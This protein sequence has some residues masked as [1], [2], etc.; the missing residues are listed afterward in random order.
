[1]SHVKMTR[2]DFLA[3]GTPTV[4]A[5]VAGR[6]RAVRSAN[7]FPYL[8]LWL[9]VE[10]RLSDLIGRMTIEAKDAQTKC[11]GSLER[12]LRDDQGNFSHA[13]IDSD[14]P[15]GLPQ[16]ENLAAQMGLTQRFPNGGVNSKE[17]IVETTGSGVAIFDYDN[18]GFPDIFIVS[19]PGGSNRLY[20]NDGR[21]HFVD[22]TRQMGLS[23]SGW[24]QGVC[25][26]DYDNDG[27]VDL[28]VTYFGHNILYHNNGGRFFEDVTA[29]A[30]LEEAE[31]R[32]GTG[33][34]FLD[35]DRDGRLDLFVANYLRFDF[36]NAPRPGANPYCWYRGL[37]VAC[38]PRGLPFPT[39]LLYRNLGNG[40]FVDVSKASGISGPHQNYSLGAL[41]SDFNGDG[42][43][44]IYV[45]CDR[46][47]SLLYINQ[48]NGTF[49]EEGLLRGVAL[50]ETGEALSGM[51]VA[52]ADYD[53]NGWLD[54]FRTNFSD[55]HVSLYR[56][57]G[58]GNFDD[59]TITAGLGASTGFVGWG[60][61]FVDF[62]NDTWRDLLWVTGHTF[63]EVDK[64]KTDIHYKDRIIL[65]RNRGNGTFAD[66][67][68]GAGPAFAERHSSRGAAFGDLDNDGAIE[69]VVNNQNECPSLLKDARKRRGN[70][71]L[72]KLEGTLSN[73][74]AIG[75][76]ALV[77]TGDSLQ[78][79]EVRSG[80]SYVSQNDLRLHFGLGKATAVDRVE[81]HWPSGI[82]QIEIGL[83]VNRVL[84]IR[85]TSQ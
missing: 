54:I 22:V 55:E 53:K 40:R 72:L 7:Q 50:D 80:G 84:T 6:A 65:Y 70:W 31:T 4:L 39:N 57:T 59:A 20:H 47:P 82:R 17:Y 34:A 74:S 30:G 66:I 63:P 67:S 9:P 13:G 14:G 77:T 68:R 8:D 42:W 81:V 62:D 85:E 19:G 51:G 25:V 18:D 35:F 37:P 79:D 36:K 12:R 10:D 11:L 44:D 60:C 64:L 83:P 46:S 32:Y 24:G 61:D 29:Q 3:L 33:C 15:F 48:R 56:N 2:R 76:R 26:G 41:V 73:R 75:A 27:F 45:A 58:H 43:P 1:M 23:H 52:A 16:L 38:G 69:I 21:G 71:I 78:I 5:G 49:T 28:F